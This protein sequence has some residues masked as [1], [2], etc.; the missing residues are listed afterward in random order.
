VPPASMHL[1]SFG[2]LGLEVVQSINGAF[3]ILRR[4]FLALIMLVLDSMGYNN[5]STTDAV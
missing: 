1:V 5:P 2:F 4:L 3:F